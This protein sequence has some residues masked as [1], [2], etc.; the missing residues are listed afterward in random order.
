MP[1]RTLPNAHDAHTLLPNNV[2][3]VRGPRF[4]PT[5][6]RTGDARTGPHITSPCG[7]AGFMSVAQQHPWTWSVDCPCMVTSL[8]RCQ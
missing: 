8:S 6:S 1:T 2:I 4:M 3:L 7:I 5:R